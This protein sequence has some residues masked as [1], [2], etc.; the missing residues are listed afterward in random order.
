MGWT[1]SAQATGK[2]LLPRE[3]YL[4]SALW[5]RFDDRDCNVPRWITEARCSVM[6][7]PLSGSAEV[8]QNHGIE[9]TNVRYS[10]DAP[11]KGLCWARYDHDSQNLSLVLGLASFA[12][13]RPALDTSLLHG[14]LQIRIATGGGFSKAENNPHSPQPTLDRFQ[15][16]DVM[17]LDQVPRIWIEQRVSE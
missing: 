6:I 12:E 1:I 11:D 3:Y 10:H 2:G 8:L 14:Q 13:L 16:G 7:S 4:L 9:P 17:V 15:A 5:H